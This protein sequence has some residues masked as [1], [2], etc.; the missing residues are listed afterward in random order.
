MNVLR[1]R[2]VG[3]SRLEAR[4]RCRVFEKRDL[5]CLINF[6][7]VWK[8][9]RYGNFNSALK[10]PLPFLYTFVIFI[11]REMFN[12]DV[13]KLVFTSAKLIFAFES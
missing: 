6:A 11:P 2:K 3:S 8:Y 4:L 12:R 13:H 9:L 7:D 10:F 1:P 5:M